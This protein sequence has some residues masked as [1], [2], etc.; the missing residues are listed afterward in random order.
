MIHRDMKE[1]K[2]PAP[3]LEE[4]IKA[5]GGTKAFVSGTDV[6]QRIPG[7]LMDEFG[8]RR[9]FLIADENT[10]RVVGADFEREL[11]AAG[12]EIAGRHIFP[13]EPRLHGDYCHIETLVRKIAETPDVKNC[14]PVAVGAGTINDLVKRAAFELSLPYLCVPTAASVDGFTSYGAAI[15]KDDFKQT[16]PCDAPLSVVADTGVLS[17]APAWLSSSGFAD[18]AGKITAGADWIIA[19]TVADLGAKG[20]QRIEPTA[21]G[22]VQHGLYDYLAR[23]VSAAQGDEDAL[24]ALF[25]A[26]SITGFSMQYLKDSRPVSGAEHLFA[27]VWE[28]NDLSVNGNPVTHGHKVAFGTLAMTAFLEILFADLKGPPPLPGEYRRPSPEERAMQV[29]SAFAHAFKAGSPG[30]E[31]IV[32]ASMKKYPNTQNDKYFRDGIRDK[33]KD[34]REN[35]LEQLMPYADL[36]AVFVKAGCPVLPSEINLTRNDVIACARLAQM[37]RNRYTGLDLA[38]D[39]GCFE[40]VLARMEESGLYLL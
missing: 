26:L 20:F 32:E 33:W 35:V 30:L 12:T 24:G 38:W 11:C 8:S 39:L 7:L 34:L 25:E 36:K 23:S 9:I 19:D 14:V 15:L 40:T 13:A 29:K 31:G 3:G 10:L 17:R 27:H 2:L 1:K 6:Y 18:L 21:W 22:M 5:C 16:L 37:I 4:C 28:M